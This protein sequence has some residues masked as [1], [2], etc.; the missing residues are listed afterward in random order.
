MAN[1]KNELLKY[2]IS[3]DY[4]ICE[5]GAMIF[6]SDDNVIKSTYLN[7]E[8]VLT[9]IDMINKNNYKYI[10]DDG[11]NYI[12]NMDVDITKLVCIFLYRNT[13]KNPEKTLSEIINSTNTYSYL[14]DNNINI[15]NKS[16]NKLESLKYLI[17]IIGIKDN[18]YTIGDA[19][20]D[21]S[22]IEYYQG[23]I[24]S[25]HEKELNQLPNK[26]YD[27]L[28]DYIEELIWFLFSYNYLGDYMVD[29]I[30]NLINDYGYFGM[31]LGMVLE[32]VI[33]II[34]SEA[35]LAT[36]GILAAKKIFTL[37]GAFLVG[38]I[39]SVFC[40]IVIYFMGYFGG[41][42][43]IKKYGKYFF[44][45]E[46]DLDK[47]DSWF[48][49]YGMM[50]ALIGRNFPIIRTLISLPIGIMRL[51]FTKF[52]IYTIIG[53]IP[54]TFIF[55]Y[56]GYTLGNGWTIMNK[57]TGKLKIPIRI[58]LAVLIISYFYKKIKNKYIKKN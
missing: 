34:P 5:N 30:L 10:L 6:D 25:R 33:I 41:R 35:I 58:L 11:Y 1:I 4:L 21:I 52:L 7:K 28:K 45:Q 20:N 18:I 2:N 24:M 36:G 48:N 32:A 47:S 8:D 12:E 15:V 40:A 49:K 54:W 16:V 55:V 44:M 26:N 31:F 27:T 53:S 19:V 50:S 37:W 13:V 22:M 51:S 43:F 3:Y 29:F 17:N 56:V 14:S 23:G 39:G 42:P 38:L 57:Y 9:I 46:E